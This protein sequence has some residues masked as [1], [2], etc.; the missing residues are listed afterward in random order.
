MVV[1]SSV[2]KKATVQAGLFVIRKP[3][4][5][6]TIE[7]CWHF[8]C[9][10]DSAL[11]AEIRILPHAVPMTIQQFL[12]GQAGPVDVTV[13]DEFLYVTLASPTEVKTS[14]AA[15]A[16]PKSP[17]KVVAAKSKSRWSGL[18]LLALTTLT[19]IAIFL[20]LNSQLG[21]DLKKLQPSEVI[22]WDQFRTSMQS[23]KVG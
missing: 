6:A 5:C 2:R 22:D 18:R 4:S 11:P 23:D 19:T 10:D 9:Q 1:W 15:T 17:A 16:S 8:I 14:K 12:E 3:C 7:D 20:V 21:S 13:R